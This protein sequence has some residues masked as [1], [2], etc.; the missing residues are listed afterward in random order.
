[1]SFIVA[2]EF[3][4]FFAYYINGI[5]VKLNKTCYN[6]LHKI[7]DRLHQQK[8]YIYAKINDRNQ[9]LF[10]G[11]CIMLLKLHDVNIHEVDTTLNHPFVAHLKLENLLK[12]V[13]RK[14]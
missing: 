10:I 9:H 3:L 1:M 7:T 8:P 2:Y 13:F 6:A 4:I 5:S 12:L 11:A 14:L